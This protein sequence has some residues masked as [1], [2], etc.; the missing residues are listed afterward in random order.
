MIMRHD[1]VARHVWTCALC[2]LS[3]GLSIPPMRTLIEESMVWHMSIQMPAIILT[4]WMANS[5]SIAVVRTDRL[6]PWNR[7]GLTGFIVAQGVLAYWM[8]PLAIDRAVVVPHVDIIKLSTLLIC[9]VI[10]QDSFSRAPAVLQLFFVGYLVSMMT[11]LGIFYATTDLRLCNAYSQVSQARAGR[12]VASLGIA[13]GIGWG[14]I[15]VGRLM[16]TRA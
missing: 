8:L 16:N 9:G 7:Y 15:G 11:W 1:L 2:V 12:A 6:A 3:V 13:L 4:G 10:L 14:A 5:H